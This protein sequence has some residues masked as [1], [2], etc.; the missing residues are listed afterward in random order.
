MNGSLKPEKRYR[1]I[2]VIALYPSVLKFEE[3]FLLATSILFRFPI[4]ILFGR[5][6]FLRL[7]ISDV[8]GIREQITIQIGDTKKEM[9]SG[10]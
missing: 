8:K 3:V 1:G 7:G 5:K 10:T 4:R 9:G 2:Y 6:Y